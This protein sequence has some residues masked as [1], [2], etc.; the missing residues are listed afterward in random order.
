MERSAIRDGGA[1]HVLLPD[2]TSFHPG[3]EERKKKGSG[4][5]TDAY[6]T[7]RIVSDAAAR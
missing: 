4:T 3:Y 1:A 5:P 7:V 6:P 2:F